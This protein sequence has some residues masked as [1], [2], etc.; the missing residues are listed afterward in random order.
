MHAMDIPIFCVN[1][2]KSMWKSWEKADNPGKPVNQPRLETN[3][4]KTGNFLDARCHG[5]LYL[6]L[7]NAK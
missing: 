3:P 7:N 1:F 5:Y 2:N 6:T 4:A